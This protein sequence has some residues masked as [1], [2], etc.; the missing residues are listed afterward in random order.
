MAR[1]SRAV[2]MPG[3]GTW[4]LRELR[5][6]DPPPGGGPPLSGPATGFPP[7]AFHQLVTELSTRTFSPVE[8]CTHVWP[9]VAADPNRLG[10]VGSR[11]EDGEVW[12]AVEH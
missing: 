9:K 12:L 5:V 2:V 3:D 11:A 8:E 7:G 10:A 4:E 6:P 1:M